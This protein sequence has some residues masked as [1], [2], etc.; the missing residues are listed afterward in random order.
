MRKGSALLLLSF[1]PVLYGMSEPA[2]I[3][4]E[5]KE[6]KI[7]ITD[8]QGVSHSLKGIRC[9]DGT[10]RLKR[11]ALSYS[12]PLSSVRR[13]TS[14]SSAGGNVRVRVEFV[15]G[16]AEEFEISATTRCVSES[17]VGTVSFHMAEIREMELLQG[18]SR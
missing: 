2:P 11:G 18:E 6:V 9:S 17:R 7:R 16:S 8:A 15:D 12:V 3:P 4:S 13:I 5:L 10:L 14:L 1:T